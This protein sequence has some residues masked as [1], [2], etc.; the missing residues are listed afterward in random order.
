MVGVAQ[1]IRRERLWCL[2]LLTW[3]RGPE[4]GRRRALLE[5]AL[6]YGA[7]ADSA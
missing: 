1:A 7:D 6:A 2:S 3:I 5:R 4:R